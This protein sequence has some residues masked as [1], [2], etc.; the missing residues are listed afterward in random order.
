[1]S[2]A[3]IIDVR[4]VR[5]AFDPHYYASQN[6][7]VIGGDLFAHFCQ[8]GWRENR[9]PSASFC[10]RL[11][12]IAYPQRG[13]ALTNPLI[14]YILRGRSSGHKAFAVPQ[15]WSNLPAE[16]AFIRDE[17]DAKF[18]R[19][20][21]PDV[22]EDAFEHYCLHGW[23]EGRD[24]TP[25][26][27]S[28]AYWREHDDVARAGVHAFAHYLL[29]GREQGRSVTS[30]VAQ[31]SVV[32]SPIQFGIDHP[33][34]DR[35]TAR[36]RVT[37]Q[38]LVNGWAVSPNGIARVKVFLDDEYQADAHY[39]SR[40][41]DVAA[42]FPSIS[43]ARASGF[44]AALLAPRRPG[45][46]RARIEIIDNE[47][48]ER[49]CEFTFQENAPTDYA[50]ELI[51]SKMAHAEVNFWLRL[52]DRQGVRPTTTVIVHSGKFP[53]DGLAGTMLSL[54]RQVYPATVI[55]SSDDK[56]KRVD[57]DLVIYVTA[58][59]RLGVDA[60]LRFAIAATEHRDC[61]IFYADERRYD[62]FRK[63]MT[64]FLKP[65]WSPTFLLSLNYVGSCWCVR[66]RARD[67]LK[68]TT[69]FAQLLR[70]TD[71]TT[72]PV[73]HVKHVLFESHSQ[74]GVSSEAEL[75]DAALRRRG[76]RASVASLGGNLYDIRQPQR[77]S[78]DLVSIIV[79]TIGRYARIRTLVES[80]KR[81]TS[82]EHY[83]II[84]IDGIDPNDPLKS[85][86]ASHT[87]VIPA[88][89]Q[90]NWSL[91][92]NLG[93][94]EARGDYFIFLNDDTEITDRH[95]IQALLAQAQNPGVGVVGPLLL[96]PD[97]T[98]QHAGMAL[99]RGAGIHVFRRAPGDTVG[100]F[101]ML[102]VPREVT[103]LTGA[104]MM[105]SK[106]TLEQ[107]GRFDERHAVVNNDL[108]F[109]LR[110]RVAG[111]RNIFTPQTS[112]IHH[113]ETSRVDLPD[114]YDECA[115]EKT[116]WRETLLS[117][118][119]SHPHLVHDHGAWQPT[120]EP[121]ETLHVGHP[122]LGKVRRILIV[123][124]DHLGDFI[125][126]RPAIERLHGLFPQ[127][128]LTAMVATASVP[129]ARAMR[130]LDE[131]I[132]FN[133]FKARSSAGKVRPSRDQL[134]ALERKL[135]AG[136][137]DLALDLRMLGDTR[138]LLQK[139]GATWLAGFDENDAHPWLDIAVEAAPDK[140]MARK[141]QHASDTLIRLI[142]AI[143]EACEDHRVQPEDLQREEARVIL[144][145]HEM[146]GPLAVA[147]DP[148]I[149]VQPGGGSPI[150]QWPVE[151]F[152]NLADL[153]ESKHRAQIVLIGGADEVAIA[154]RIQRLTRG[155]RT[156]S[157]VGRT[158]LSDLETILKAADLMIGN[159]SGPHHLAAAL[160]TP[161]IGIHAG[162]VDAQEWGPKGP[163][164][165][166][167]GKA[168]H[169]RP[170]YLERKSECHRHHDCMTG[171]LPHHVLDLCS[172]MM[173]AKPQ[174]E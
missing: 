30:P 55:I 114:D 101:G 169:C 71:D 159:N 108:D 75:I 167:V 92:N 124:V 4:A 137:F 146:L 173:K 76:R 85:W 88:P 11:Y 149:V 2:A 172:L 141:R 174:I 73:H 44:S 122:M 66:N 107:V 82:H 113:E 98:I 47:G 151:H 51:K 35:T 81:L 129:F 6:P 27:S 89:E 72:R 105:V 12:Q 161:T 128:R 171:V 29:V 34:L 110:C 41:P 126:A 153:L 86:L 109:C 50:Y 78:S 42:T 115:F 54:D 166:T 74:G 67:G 100:P 38:L 145:N 26:F 121:I 87:R 60:L 39:G 97:G 150:K 19:S 36:Q 140:R 91:C 111:L 133:V 162:F 59:D 79:P 135:V 158:S 134:D 148:L 43:E 93:L 132:E 23:R 120:S 48:H 160:G 14:H 15:R 45:T 164:A 70:L 118:P 99:V 13:D 131:V 37:G 102:R 77:K 119:Y 103:A 52:L 127:A 125:I 170:C 31:Q 112:L 57:T 155:N 130:C 104:C 90:F 156:I 94:Q 56:D 17:F 84:C 147:G 5:D 96:Y 25:W 154:K 95:W 62:P 3:N 139:S 64:T 20:R 8:R 32:I 106:A 83:E 49:H 136:N 10:I 157:L 24:P 33:A 21:Y 63:A 65:D 18:Y 40:R 46:H 1:M 123:K 152:A 142:S 80:I 116:W 143:A 16:A 163:L 168:T 22:G 9:D 68:G 28:L 53:A 144:H 117:D 61:D 138:Y 7:D 165:V 69:P 58:G